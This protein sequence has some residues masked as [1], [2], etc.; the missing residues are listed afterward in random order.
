MVFVEPAN[1]TI[2]P[3]IPQFCVRDAVAFQVVDSHSGNSARGDWVG[4]LPG[5]VRPLL[6]W[7]TEY[8]KNQ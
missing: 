6:T 8:S 4:D 2:N 7:S 5:I 1:T 3:L